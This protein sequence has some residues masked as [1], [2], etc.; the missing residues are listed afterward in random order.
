MPL[1][2]YTLDE[3]GRRTVQNETADY[4]RDIDLTSQAEALFGFIKETIEVE[5]V[6]ELRFLIHYDKAKQAIQEIVDMPDRLIDLFI[7][8]CNQ[9]HG[10]LSSAG[11]WCSRFAVRIRWGGMVF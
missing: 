10:K 6:K 11:G 1:I 2:D 4:Y 3:Q 5:L 9:N 8:F 7:R